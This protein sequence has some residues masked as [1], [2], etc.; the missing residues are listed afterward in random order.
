[1]YLRL[2]IDIGSADEVTLNVKSNGEKDLTAFIY[3]AQDGT[4]SG[5]NPNKTKE[6]KKPFVSGPLGVKDGKLA[7]EV[8]I[9]RSLVETFFNDTKSISVRSYSA[10]ESQGISLEADGEITVSELYA[11]EMRSIY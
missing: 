9:D 3:N 11:A 5:K 4:I 10:F 7:M 2:A 8:Y 6:A 1:M